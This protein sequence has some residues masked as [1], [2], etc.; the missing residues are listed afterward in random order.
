MGDQQRRLM[1]RL[2]RER[3]ITTQAGRHRYVGDV[4]ARKVDSSAQLTA[5]EAAL[6]IAR[7][8][9]EQ[10]TARPAANEEGAEAEGPEAPPLPLEE[11]D[12][13]R[14]GAQA[15]AGRRAGPPLPGPPHP[16]IPCG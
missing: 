9:A 5:D 13:D 12:R 4:L 3:G 16:W 15:R 6:V 8:E 2:L 1:M 14:R 11:G 10:A 7:L